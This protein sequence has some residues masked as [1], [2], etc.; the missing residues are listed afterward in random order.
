MSLSEKYLGVSIHYS[1]ALNGL[2]EIIKMWNFEPVTGIGF[3]NK[4]TGHYAHIEL[5]IHSCKEEFK[6]NKIV[7]NI[8]ENQLPLI[9]RNEIERTLNLFICYLNAIKENMT[10]I[11]YCQNWKNK[12]EF[13]NLTT[14][15]T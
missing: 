4:Y 2:D 12:I 9:F 5:E 6:R 1:R 15:R 13:A 10:E 11:F 7:Y 8:C 3:I 14:Q